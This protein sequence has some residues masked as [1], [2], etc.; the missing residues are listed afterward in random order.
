MKI[1]RITRNDRWVKRVVVQHAVKMIS[2][3]PEIFYT[4][5]SFIFSHAEP[6][7]ISSESTLSTF[8]VTHHQ[9]YTV[10]KLDVNGTSNRSNCLE[11]LVAA[12]MFFGWPKMAKT[13]KNEFS[14]DEAG[15]D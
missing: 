10:S 11:F 3:L 7:E 6:R 14:D 5:E 8:L 12:H 1:H 4:N 9:E 2:H 15:R 13:S